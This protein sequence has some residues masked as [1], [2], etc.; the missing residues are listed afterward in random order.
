MRSS[1]TYF[2]MLSQI[3]GFQDVN[4]GILCKICSFY[5][6]WKGV[7]PHLAWEMEVLCIP[8]PLNVRTQSYPIYCLHQVLLSHPVKDS[9]W[10]GLIAFR[11]LSGYE[12][13]GATIRK[14]SIPTIWIEYRNTATWINSAENIKLS[15][16]T[17]TR[18]WH[19][20]CLLRNP[21]VCQFYT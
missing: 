3:K 2:S 19:M 20:G 9:H 6:N 11:A 10:L 16:K 12:T 17:P 21:H 13:I 4:Y 7:S 1:N 14:V 8:G 15:T 18:N 5:P